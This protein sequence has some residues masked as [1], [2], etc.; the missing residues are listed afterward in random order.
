MDLTACAVEI[1]SRKNPYSTPASTV[2]RIFE[3]LE[4]IPQ[5]TYAPRDDIF[6]TVYGCGTTVIG[7]CHYGPKNRR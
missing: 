7:D 4:R 3:I 5:P 1:M 2:F 6:N